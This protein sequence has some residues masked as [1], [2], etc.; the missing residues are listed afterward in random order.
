MT[1]PST[2]SPIVTR[3][4]KTNKSK[5]SATNKDSQDI[6]RHSIITTTADIPKFSGEPDTIPLNQYIKRVETLIINKGV[7]EENLKIECFKEHIDA[8][9]GI[10]RHIIAYSHLDDID[11][12]DEYVKVFKTHFITQSEQDPIRAMV[13][14]LKTTPWPNE[15]QAAYI[16]RLDNQA[17][18]LKSI[19]R[20]SDWS[21]KSAT[22]EEVFD[23]MVLAMMLAHIIKTT[24]G[25]VQERLY[26]DVTPNM[27]LGQVHCLLKKYSEADPTCNAYIFNTNTEDSQ[28]AYTS[29]QGRSLSRN[30]YTT[31]PRNRSTSRHRIECYNC[32][33]T[34]HTARD[35]YANIICSNCQYKGHP[36]SYCRNPPWCTYH[37]KIGHRTS[38]CRAKHQNF[39]EGHTRKREKEKESTQ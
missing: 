5:M 6:V 21:K 18:D 1:P 14:Y 31:Q 33:K 19:F 39:H 27:K 17:K 24:S 4:F 29:R 10:A 15:T 34:G 11:T 30:R 26:K 28:T 37:R 7:T 25:V 36:D 12:F 2:R 3:L 13:K 23:N 38:D 16:L 22:G 9:K 32:H 8:I 35:C 20:N